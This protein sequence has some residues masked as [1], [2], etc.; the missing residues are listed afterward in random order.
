MER[1]KVLFLNYDEMIAEPTRHVKMLAEFLRVP[2]T[3]EESRG[4]MEEVVRLCS[5]QNLKSLPVNSQ[6]VSKRNGVE[7]SSF[8]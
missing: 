2:F 8:L 7:N 4:P 1:E 3:D 6:G 5:F